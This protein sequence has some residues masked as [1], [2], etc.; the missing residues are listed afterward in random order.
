M[1]LNNNQNA[2]F[3]LVRAGL[4]EKEVLLLQFG[5]INFS[6]VYSLAE[7]QSVV[8]LVAAG[9]EHVQDVKVPQ[10]TALTFV[11][12]TLQLEQRN[13]AMNSFVESL[14]GQMQQM[15]IYSILVKGQGIALCYERPQWRAAGDVDLLLS[16]SNYDRAK[17]WL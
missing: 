3:E 5:E 6:D 7:E 12:S 15:G 13:M 14:Y 4:W 1:K 17:E 16:G 8:G 9:I 10:E 11:G 2:F